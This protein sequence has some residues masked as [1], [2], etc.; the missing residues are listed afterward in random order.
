LLKSFE[1][2][3]QPE[4]AVLT[5]L[6]DAEG[7]SVAQGWF[8]G[9]HDQL[10]IAAAATVETQRRN[11]FDYLLEPAALSLPPIYSASLRE[12]LGPTLKRGTGNVE[13]TA[14][15][16]GGANNPAANGSESVRATD[17]PVNVF[18]RQLAAEFR[19]VLTF[20]DRLNRHLH[21]EFEIEHREVGPPRPP[22]ETLEARS[23][24]CRDLAV[25]LIDAC[26]AAGVA[27]RFVSGYHLDDDERSH[28]EMHAWA[29]VFVPGGG[30]RGYD[31]TQGLA[32]TDRHV[33]VA[34]AADPADAAPVSG[35]FYGTEAKA[36]LHTELTISS[37][38]ATIDAPPRQ[39][40]LQQQQ[41]GQ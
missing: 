17:E 5:H 11:P 35:A 34:A 26:R 22:A 39:F 12:R 40:Q 19:D 18:A 10:R 21:A 4:P 16:D 33:A 32:V 30:W 36:T 28:H 14:H 2:A 38:E 25:L 29:E 27:A 1:L 23:G 9:L 15:S 6:L 41:H 31:P 7:N 37:A 24:A 20:V 13:N 8:N 3:I